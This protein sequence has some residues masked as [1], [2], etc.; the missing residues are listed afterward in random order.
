MGILRPNDAL[1][2][3]KQGNERF[4]STRALRP[5]AVGPRREMLAQEQRPFA[6]ILS[7]SDSRVP[8]EIVFDT[9]LGDL[10]VVRVAGNVANLS[11]IAS[12]E[13][14]V[15][16]IGS[17]LVLVMGHERCGAV[18]ATIAGG[19]GGKHLNH[20]MSYI[21]PAV[22]SDGDDLDR[23]ARRNTQ[24]SAKRLLDQSEIIRT[25]IDDGNL[26]IATAFFHFAD[27][28]VEFD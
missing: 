27:G 5:G 28:R 1:D 17:Q 14:A 19:D 21:H 8:P 4:L 15:S 7:C 3:L 2:Q 13:Y 23:V 18:A 22:G 25:A 11:S 20:L 26:K 12:V 6:I 10:F 24:L 16:Q 9:R